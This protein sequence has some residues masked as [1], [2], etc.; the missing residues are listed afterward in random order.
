[1]EQYSTGNKS[2]KGCFPDRLPKLLAVDLGLRTGLALYGRDG[3]LVW[4]RSRHFANPAGLRSRLHKLLNEI[5]DLAVIF[6]EGGGSLAD[7]WR[8]EAARRGIEV[9]LIGAED[10]RSDLL[11]P[12]HQKSTMVAKRAAGRMARI[13]IE[14]SG[15]KRPTSLRHDAAEAILIG[16]WSAVELGWLERLPDSLKSG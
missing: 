8:K 10:W 13:V 12:R 3:R 4:Y 1:M 16:I 14:W 9:R 2:E 15:A 11:Y 6:I 5:P 7:I